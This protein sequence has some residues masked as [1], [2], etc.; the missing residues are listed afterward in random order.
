MKKNIISTLM[1]T[2]ILL[3]S[4]HS[5]SK[6]GDINFVG[7]IIDNACQVTTGSDA[8]KVVLGKVSKTTLSN[9][10]S[11]AAATKFT[12]QLENCP[13]TIK[14]ATVKF[15]GASYNGNNDVLQLT[16]SGAADTAQNVGIQIQDVT[17]T[18]VPLYTASSEYTLK[19][20]V[21]NNLDFTARYI[22]MSD[23]V[24]V[25]KADSTATF[26]INYN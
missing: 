20:S 13:A 2:S 3:L 10:G 1:A 25:G 23:N 19:E 24:S 8:I 18:T 5:F 11:T 14:T 4:A 6:D 16:N 17:G 12:I 15:D 21:V 9:A 22:A 7:E 26:T